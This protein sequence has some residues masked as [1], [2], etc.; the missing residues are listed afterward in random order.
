MILGPA[1]LAHG[2]SRAPFLR[3]ALP[4]GG[5]RTARRRPSAGG[6]SDAMPPTP[7]TML[8][9]CRSQFLPPR[10]RSANSR[11]SG[12]RQTSGGRSSAG[13][14]W[15]PSPLW[16][17]PTT[18]QQRRRPRPITSGSTPNSPCTPSTDSP[19]TR[20]SSTAP[21]P[22]A[23]RTWSSTPTAT[24]STHAPCSKRSRAST[25]PPGGCKPLHTSSWLSVSAS[26]LTSQIKVLP[27]GRTGRPRYSSWLS[28]VSPFR[29]MLRTILP[30]PVHCGRSS[31]CPRSWWGVLPST[32]GWSPMPSGQGT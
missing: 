27:G 6:H 30:S 17:S 1:G 2:P 31:T 25:A 12:G 21:L 9:C 15:P 13:H 7:W 18:R 8:V 16:S 23:A 29:L 28:R 24:S 14:A 11:T 3:H 5:S 20:P 19:R 32:T 26:T 10:R 4:W 22:W